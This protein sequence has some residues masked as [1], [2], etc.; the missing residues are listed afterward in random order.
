MQT[1][2]AGIGAWHRTEEDAIRRQN[3]LTQAEIDV[4]MDANEA[5]KAAQQ[6]A[7]L[8]LACVACGATGARKTTQRGADGEPDVQICRTLACHK[9]WNQRTR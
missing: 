2:Y 3:P 5:E 7:L 9:Q 8:A 1:L 6:A 4:I